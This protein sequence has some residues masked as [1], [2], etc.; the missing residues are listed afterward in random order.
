[1]KNTFSLGRENFP[2]AGKLRG[3]GSPKMSAVT[4]EEEHEM[5]KTTAKLTLSRETLKNLIADGQAM[6]VAGGVASEGVA[7]TK[8]GICTQTCGHICP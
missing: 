6:R 7:C 3:G 4:A 1:L 8:L 2:R 5:K